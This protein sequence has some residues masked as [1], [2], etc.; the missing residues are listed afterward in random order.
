MIQLRAAG[1][2]CFKQGKSKKKFLLMKHKNRFDL[3]KGHQEEGE[4]DIETALR[5]LEEETGI[6][7]DQ[8]EI[9]QDF[10]F[11]LQYNPKYKR[12]GKTGS[13]QKLWSFFWDI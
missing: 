3:P 12:F 5:E 9:D 11:E 8:I 10:H 13:L 6:S 1:V 2:I 4:T 7:A